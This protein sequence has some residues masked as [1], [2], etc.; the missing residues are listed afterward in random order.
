MRIK[1]VLDEE[2]PITA[3]ADLSAFLLVFIILA[4]SLLFCVKSCDLI[5]THQTH[6]KIW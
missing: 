4:K 6:K 1:Q 3:D 5:N 2:A